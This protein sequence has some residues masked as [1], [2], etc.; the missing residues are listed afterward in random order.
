MLTDEQ[1]AAIKDRAR[2]GRMIDLGVT[3]ADA[4][5]AWQAFCHEMTLDRDA[6]L[7]EVERLRAWRDVTALAD[8]ERAA[9]YANEQYVRGE[10]QQAADGSW[11]PVVV[12]VNGRQV[13]RAVSAELVREMRLRDG[14]KNF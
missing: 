13:A 14:P 4:S 5:L 2:P 12:R 1:L 10:D 3:P 6:L 9:F 8:S 7:A 11:F